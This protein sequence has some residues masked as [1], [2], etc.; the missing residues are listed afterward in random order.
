M[1]S[2]R[3][4][5]NEPNVSADRPLNHSISADDNPESLYDMWKHGYF[6]IVPDGNAITDMWGLVELACFIAQL[7]RSSCRYTCRCTCSCN[8]SSNSRLSLIVMALILIV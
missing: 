4:P 6:T 2:Q 1:G 8:S 5:V 3:L 7:L